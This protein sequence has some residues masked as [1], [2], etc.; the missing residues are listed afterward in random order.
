M[1]THKLQQAE[2]KCIQILEE[3]FSVQRMLPGTFKQVY[4]KCGKENCWCYNKGAAGHPFRRITWSADG[5]THTQTIPL[6]DIDWIIKVTGNY[7]AFKKNR[8]KLKYFEEYL[9]TLIDEH[10]NNIIKKTRA[11]KKYL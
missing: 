8:R 10:E 4:C 5:R 11:L 7:R 9:K 2:N 6:K 3:L 1:S